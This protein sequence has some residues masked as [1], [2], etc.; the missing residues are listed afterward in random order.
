MRSYPAGVASGVFNTGHEVGGSLGIAVVSA[1]AATSVAAMTAPSL[2]GFRHAF[3]VLAA[4]AAVLAA[5]A[6]VL[7]PKGPL[8]LGDSPMPMH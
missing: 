8:D 1:V 7:L 4:G 5:A 2:T 3:W 6:T